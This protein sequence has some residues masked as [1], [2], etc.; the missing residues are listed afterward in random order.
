MLK[1]V[2]KNRLKTVDGGV[3]N[4][5]S[6]LESHWPKKTPQNYLDEKGNL[7]TENE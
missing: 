5:A 7:L 2:F 4:R 1:W 6:P 3:L